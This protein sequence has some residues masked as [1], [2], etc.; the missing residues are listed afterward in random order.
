MNGRRTTF[1]RSSL[2]TIAF[3]AALSAPAATP[4]AVAEPL[5][6]KTGCLGRTDVLGLSRIVEIDT[7]AGPRFGE[8]YDEN[9]FL[10]EGEVVL[11][12]DDGP[13]RRFTEPILDVLDAHCVKATFFSVGRMAVAAPDMVKE[14]YRRGH[15]IGSHTWSHANLRRVSTATAKREMELG[16][17]AVRTALGKP[18]SPFFRF[19]YLS[20]PRSA[21]AHLRQRGLG[22]FGIDV[23]SRD[24]ETRSGKRMTQRVLA[25]LKKKGKGIILFH[26]IQKSTVRGLAGLLAE[27]K[28]RK[29]KIVHMVAKDDAT[30]SAKYDAIAAKKL[31]RKSANKRANPLADRAVTW[32]ASSGTGAGGN[33]GEALPWLKKNKPRK[34]KRRPPPQTTQSDYQS[35]WQMH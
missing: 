14:I 32:P 10:E 22:I 20:D 25:G 8:Q 18:I 19:P 5:A 15:T 21:Q 23:D 34:V 35:R 16:L 31:R 28:A 6:L 12:F 13:V 29:Y 9:H 26:D 4:A 33:T 1:L 11:T 7:S 3:V 30:T 24:F 27:L 2:A 17:S